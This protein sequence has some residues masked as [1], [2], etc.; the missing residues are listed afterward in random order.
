MPDIG[1]GLANLGAGLGQGLAAAGRRR[2]REKEREEEEERRKRA[3]KLALQMRGAKEQKWLDKVDE[4]VPAEQILAAYKEE[5]AQEES[6]AR[7]AAQHEVDMRALIKDKERGDLSVRATHELRMRKL[8]QEA[9]QKAD[10]DAADDKFKSF[11]TKTAQEKF[12]LPPDQ[13]ALMMEG[14]RTIPSEWLGSRKESDPFTSARRQRAAEIDNQFNKK[15]AET[16]QQFIQQATQEIGTLEDYVKKNYASD[17]QLLQSAPPEMT[18]AF[19]QDKRGKYQKVV[20]ERIDDLIDNARIEA[21]RVLLETMP[22]DGGE[23]LANEIR[24]RIAQKR[25][26]IDELERRINNVLGK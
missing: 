16:R 9:E 19:Y 12:N 1:Q 20:E 7:A 25:D 2:R 8:K 22:Y 14:R 6:K 15:R 4:G 26:K 11:G 24:N 13:A 10:Q 18:S 3:A 23:D 17:L 21:K 5:K